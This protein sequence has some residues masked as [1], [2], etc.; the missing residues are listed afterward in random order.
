MGQKD[1]M[2]KAKPER[3]SSGKIV[4]GL[5]TYHRNELLDGALESLSRIELPSEVGV[6][7]VLVDNDGDGG[8]RP[9]FEYYVDEFP[10]KS[11]YFVEPNQGLVCARNRVL[12]EALKLGATEIAFFDDDEIVTPDWL[13][14]LWNV[15]SKSSIFGCGGQVYRLLPIKHDPLLEKFWPNCAQ[16][17][18][19]STNNCLFSA[20]LVRPDGFALRFDPSLNQV[21]GEDSKLVLEALE[22]GAIFGFVKD[23]VA[24]ERFTEQ[25]ATFSYLL[26]RFFGCG[27]FA[28][29]VIPKM[30]K[31]RVC[32][33]LKSIFSCLWRTAFIPISLCCGRFQFWK[34]LTKLTK[35]LGTVAACFG[36]IYKYYKPYDRKINK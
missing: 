4:I 8:A 7:F 35:S 9:I 26:K 16:E 5:C 32:Y 23:A 25:R 34:N 2:G 30:G 24:V 21:G 36:F 13:K 6:E 10:F 12:D 3:S 31:S 19:M 22:R 15:Y 17:K 11:Y 20:D 33:V 14:A 27:G 18:L 28:L 1:G 29:T